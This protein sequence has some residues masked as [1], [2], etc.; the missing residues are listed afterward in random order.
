MLVMYGN[1]L[2]KKIQEDIYKQVELMY[3][4][5]RLSV[6]LV[7]DNSASHIYVSAKQKACEKVGIEF[8][9][10]HFKETVSES[11]VLACIEALN[12]D[13]YVSGILV[14]MPLPK[15]LNEKNILGSIDPKKDVDGL[16]TFN[17]GQLFLN[18]EGLRPCTPKGIM[19]LLEHYDVP[20]SGKRAVVV[21]RSHLVG[22]PI[23]KML[24]DANATVTI[25]HSKTENLKAICQQADILVVAI[26]KA[27]WIDASYV[28]PGAT[29]IDVGIN[30]LENGRL[31]GDTDFES[32]CSIAHITPVPKGVG[33][34]TI[35]MLLE[36]VV[37]AAKKG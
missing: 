34:M 31:C 37:S 7:G 10:Y 4:K 26:G 16:T 32:I 17:M 27:K 1:A 14:Q 20:I 6:V 24:L 22:L 28:K 30:R 5:P 3:Q 35:A 23:S 36:N 19:A 15:H 18:E 12:E 21:G 8:Q 13:D 33:P 2:F 29:V 11:E 9:L 25:C